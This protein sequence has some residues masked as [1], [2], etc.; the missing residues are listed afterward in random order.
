MGFCGCA[1]D[2]W[3]NIYMQFNTSIAIKILINQGMVQSQERNTDLTYSTSADDA[4]D[5][6]FH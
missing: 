1:T 6:I 4:T 5:L 2:V 3:L